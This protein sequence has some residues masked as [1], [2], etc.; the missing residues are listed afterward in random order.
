MLSLP[1]IRDELP[2]LD[3]ERLT[4]K[5]E[6]YIQYRLRGL[7]PLAAAKRAQLGIT[8]MEQ[9]NALHD[10]KPQLDSALIY[11]RERVREK[12]INDGVEITFTRA[13]AHMMYLHAHSHA[14]DATEEIRAVDSMVKLWGLAAPEKKQV[15]ITNK[16]Q[17][18]MLSDQELQQLTGMTYNLDPGDYKVSH[19]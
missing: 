17:L 3:I 9:L 7:T 8:N 15:E 12:A 10:K 4:P 11:F 14:A 2:L 13:D 5:E 6:L 16:K 18:E 1:E 19:D